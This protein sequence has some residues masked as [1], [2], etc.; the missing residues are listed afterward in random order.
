MMSFML[1]NFKIRRGNFQK[2]KMLGLKILPEEE[3]E[4]PVLS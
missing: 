4:I 2:K 3:N 1:Q